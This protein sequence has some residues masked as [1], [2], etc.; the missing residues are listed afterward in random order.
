MMRRNELDTKLL[1]FDRIVSA[2]SATCGIAPTHTIATSRSRC[3]LQVKK[4]GSIYG[5]GASPARQQSSEAARTMRLII[6]QQD[7]FC[8]VR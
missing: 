4:S 5:M 8:R 2:R 7:A 6:G 1:R 3:T